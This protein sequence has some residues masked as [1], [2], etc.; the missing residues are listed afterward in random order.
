LAMKMH[1]L[2]LDW[3]LQGVLLYSLAINYSWFS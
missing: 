1:F 3:L 2:S